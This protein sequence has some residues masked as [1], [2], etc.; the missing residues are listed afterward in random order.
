MTLLRKSFK[1]K[2]I[3]FWILICLGFIGRAQFVIHY[4]AS[5]QNLTSCLNSSLLTVRV[6]VGAN[7]TANDTVFISFPPGITYIPGSITKTGGTSTL[8]IVEAGGPPEAP[9]FLITPANLTVGQN[10]TFTLQRQANCISRN[11]VIE[12][13]VFKDMISIKGTAG[14]TRD[15]DP[16]FNAYNVNFPSISFIQPAA[17]TN[18]VPGGIYSRNFTITNGGNGCTDQV[19]FYIV[20]PDAGLE[21]QSLTLGGILI[22]STSVKGDTLFFTVQGAALTSDALLCNGENLVFK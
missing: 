1:R 18:I 10:I 14:I 13:G 16:T 15:I 6:D 17:L 21:F 22:P 8:N 11:Y 4:P 3:L 5:S 7:A 12:G 9:R 19:H 2:A 20:Y